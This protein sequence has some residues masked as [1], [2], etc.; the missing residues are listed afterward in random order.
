M[1]SL[2]SLVT[3]K[4]EA[5]GSYEILVP[6]KATRCNTLKNIRHFYRRENIPEDNVLRPYTGDLQLCVD[7]HVEAIPL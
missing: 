4:T 1:E 6:T 5:I 2:K 7:S 3:L